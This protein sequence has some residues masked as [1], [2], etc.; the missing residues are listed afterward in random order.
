MILLV[1]V[2]SV[3]NSVITRVLDPPLGLGFIG[4]F[5]KQHG[6]PIKLL[7]FAS[8]P[9]SLSK[10]SQAVL[11]FKP[12]LVGFTCYNSNYYL[13][14]K[15]AT[16]LKAQIPFLKI[17]IGGPTPTFSAQEIFE[18]TKVF[19]FIVRGEGER[20]V[21]DLV[22]VIESQSV[23]YQN[24]EGISY[25]K[26]DQVIHTPNRKLEMDLDQFPSPYLEN[27]FEMDL[28]SRGSILAGR[29]CNQ[30]CMFCNCGIMFG[31]TIRLHSIQRI[32]SEI[33]KLVNEYKITEV[34][35]HDDA[36]STNISFA[37]KVLQ[38]IISR[39]YKLKL[40]METRIDRID[41]ELLELMVRANVKQMNF[42]L[43]SGDPDILKFIRKVRYSGPG[44]EPENKFLNA[45][46][47]LFASP[48]RNKINFTYSFIIGHPNE[49][50]QNALNTLKL[51]KLLGQRN[52]V[53]NVLALAQGTEIWDRKNE[54]GIKYERH[55]KMLFPYKIL[56][57]SKMSREEILNIESQIP[58]NLLAYSY[59]HLIPKMLTAQLLGISSYE[60]L[61]QISRKSFEYPQE[62]MVKLFEN[63][64]K[65]GDN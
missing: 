57:F 51:V 4:A 2:P 46:K 28:Y 36:F 1:S 33:D 29:G 48:W 26:G 43:E 11:E 64:L 38:E 21:L 25:L 13:I 10:I 53:P 15:I 52:A 56:Q 50:Y 42:G 44:S 3:I 12:T 5:L 47:T 30:R 65:Y 32:L 35:F 37:K 63:Y 34:H 40:W 55:K 9:M 17:M 60:E 58:N 31:H 54:F 24:I 22:K 27:I 20:T 45:F 59:T 18:D 6:Y 61:G 14:K 16:Q 23:D 41:E 39:D 19:D 7:D 49:T 62:V 8:N